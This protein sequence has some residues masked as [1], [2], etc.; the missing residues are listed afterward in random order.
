MLTLWL[1]GLIISLVKLFVKNI[2][3]VLQNA[4][5]FSLPRI[6]RLLSIDHQ[7]FMLV[8]VLAVMLYC[9][10]IGLAPDACVLS[11]TLNIIC[12]G[13][14]TFMRRQLDKEFLSL[15]DLQHK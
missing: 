11:L 10:F 12:L 7:V 5:V 2:T 6:S 3:N 9:E 15:K 4:I 8:S 14:I 1:W 13:L